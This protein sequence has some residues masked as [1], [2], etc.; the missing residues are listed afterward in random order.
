MLGAVGRGVLQLTAPPPPCAVMCH[1]LQPRSSVWRNVRRFPN[2]EVAPGIA[3][4]RFDAQLYFAN[5]A[6]FQVRIATV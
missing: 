2:A 6:V 3:V 5:T 1:A 4:V